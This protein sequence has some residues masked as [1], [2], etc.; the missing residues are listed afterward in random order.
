[1][2]WKVYDVSAEGER[3]TEENL[4]HEAR[5]TLIKTYGGEIF[6]MWK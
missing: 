4:E 6:P 5:K 2:D 1:M 3:K